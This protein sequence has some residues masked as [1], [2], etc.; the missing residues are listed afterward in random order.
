MKNYYHVF[1]DDSYTYY[2]LTKYKQV[3]KLKSKDEKEDQK[4]IF[5]IQR[6]YKKNVINIS[7]NKK[8]NGIFLFLTNYCNQNCIYCFENKNLTKS[9]MNLNTAIKVIEYFISKII[10]KNDDNHLIFFGGEP[11]LNYSVIHNLIKYMEDKNYLQ[12]FKFKIGN[13]WNFTES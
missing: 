9:K 7:K 8:R 10:K 1:F 4:L 2:F 6:K 13:K 5:K 11:L 12:F 3:I